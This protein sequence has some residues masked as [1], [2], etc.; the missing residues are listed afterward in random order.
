[1]HHLKAD[2]PNESTQGRTAL[3][4]SS[5]KLL[6][7]ETVTRRRSTLTLLSLMVCPRGTRTETSVEGIA[8]NDNPQTRFY[9][10]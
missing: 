7:D 3:P 4:T 9:A 5:S 2:A 10:L 6:L 8:M 1:M